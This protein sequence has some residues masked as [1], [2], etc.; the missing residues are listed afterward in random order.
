MNGIR[1]IQTL[2]SR[3]M[4][5][6]CFHL[7]SPADL[8]RWLSQFG[9]FFWYKNLLSTYFYQTRCTQTL[10]HTDLHF[11]QLMSNIYPQIIHKVNKVIHTLYP[12][13]SP[14]SPGLAPWK[15]KKIKFE[16]LR[17]DRPMACTKRRRQKMTQIMPGEHPSWWAECI[18][19]NIF[20]LD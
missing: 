9:F 14:P 12:G 16:H 15:R 6:M 7:A 19:W 8:S 4:G 18:L 3:R 17:T 13:N 11:D 10:C 1:Q 20:Q 2:R 5:G